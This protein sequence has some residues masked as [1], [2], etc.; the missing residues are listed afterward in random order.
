M[1][2]AEGRKYLDPEGLSRV[3]N[4]PLTARQ[5]VEGFISGKHRS[6]YQGF[7]IEYLDH[8]PYVPG[9]ELRTLDWKILARTDKHY[10][11]L[12]EQETNLRA[13]IVVDCSKSMEFAQSGVSKKTYACHLAAA[14]SF[15]LLRQNDAVGLTVFD[16]DVREYVAPR[17]HPTQFRRILSALERPESRPDTDLGAILERLADRLKR[18]GLIVLISDMIDDLDRLAKGLQFLRHRKHE[19]LVFQVMDPAELDFPFDRMT[20]FK[21]MEGA[22]LLTANPQQVRQGYLKR[23][24]AFLDRLK[25]ECLKRKVDYNLI[26]TDAPYDRALAGYLH[27]RIKLG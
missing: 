5:V 16:S 2:E 15:L 10:V 1:A 11:K 19:V 4:L 17:A 7:S 22:G 12:F 8:R 23:L 13:N 3:G 14:L 27:K 6:P 25:S 18:R 9:D 26:R 21:D 20:V 24:N